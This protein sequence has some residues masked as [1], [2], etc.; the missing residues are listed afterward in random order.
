VS[1]AGRGWKRRAG[2]LAV[3]KLL[4]GILK[5]RMKKRTATDAAMRRALARKPF[6]KPM[7][8]IFPARKFM[9]ALVFVDSNVL[10]YAIDEGNPKKHEA[11]EIVAG[12]VVEE[13]PGAGEFSGA[14]RVLCQC[15]P[16]VL[17][18]ATRF[19]PRY[20]V[21]SPGTRLLSMPKFSRVDGSFRSATN[22]VLGIR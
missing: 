11:A 5:E 20:V 7:A 18:P 2:I 3:S 16:K 17:L 14:A 13:P 4:A 19:R 9:T 6:L 21:Y 15:D 1:P 10:I 22:L 12:G 8:G